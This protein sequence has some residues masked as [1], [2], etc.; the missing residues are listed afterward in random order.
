[1]YLVAVQSVSGLLRLPG[2]NLAAANMR[3]PPLSRRH[4]EFLFSGL[5]G[6]GESLNFVSFLYFCMKT[7]LYLNQTS[8]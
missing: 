4:S 7:M 5:F 3:L 8:N 2:R 6:L 1:M